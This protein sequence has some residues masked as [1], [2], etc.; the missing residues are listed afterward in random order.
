MSDSGDDPREPRGNDDASDSG[1]VKNLNGKQTT[2][3]N[4]VSALQQRVAEL[5]MELR[6]VTEWFQ[7]QLRAERE[8]HQEE[9]QR[10][11]ERS[12]P[13]RESPHQLP[14]QRPSQAG[15]AAAPASALNTWPTAQQPYGSH[16]HP[17]EQRGAPPAAPAATAAAAAAAAATTT[18]TRTST[19]FSSAGTS[20]NSSVSTVAAVGPW[21]SAVAPSAA[22][23]AAQF[24]GSEE[25]GSE[26]ARD[27]ASQ[28]RASD[29]ADDLD[30]FGVLREAAR[31]YE[32]GIADQAGAPASQTPG[33]ATAAAA[34]AAAAASS[35]SDAQSGST[36]ARQRSSRPLTVATLAA[37]HQNALQNPFPSE[38]PAANVPA[39]PSAS[40]E[41]DDDATSDASCATSSSSADP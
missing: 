30:N 3:A 31:R 17:Q 27:I 20:S 23:A 18:T 29:V 35:A 41:S 11:R 7:R 2:S 21:M 5:E 12:N 15:A 1:N 26:D 13:E 8:R 37:S 4:D 28:E 9:L 22:A 32:E 40:T 24:N 16:T 6:R 19:P 36:A 39:S 33:G 14:E 25:V 10:E 38:P 34:A